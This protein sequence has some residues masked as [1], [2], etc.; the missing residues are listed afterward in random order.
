MMV[1]ARVLFGLKGCNEECYKDRER[2]RGIE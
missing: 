1:D 2:E